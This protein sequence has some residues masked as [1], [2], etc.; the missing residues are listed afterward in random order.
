[1]KYY[2]LFFIFLFNSCNDNN[3]KEIEDTI[4]TQQWLKHYKDTSFEVFEDQSGV[5]DTILITQY[6]D[7][8]YRMK[9]SS[10][11]NVE[12]TIERK[13]LEIV[14]N[15]DGPAMFAR[16]NVPDNSPINVSSY[17]CIEF[18][19]HSG[20]VAETLWLAC[21]KCPPTDHP[22]G[23]KISRDFGLIEFTTLEGMV[24]TRKK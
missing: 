11:E 4:K 6:A 3:R 2:I 23:F 9:S 18:D 24:F 22:F 5:L 14:I 8:S 7:E 19:Q 21:C 13:G 1:M 20:H 15:G 10:T 16:F 12:I 17:A